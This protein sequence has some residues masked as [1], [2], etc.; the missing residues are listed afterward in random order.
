MISLELHNVLVLVR[1]RGVASF[2]VAVL[3]MHAR[4]F[5]AHGSFTPSENLQPS[6]LDLSPIGGLPT[7]RLL[8]KLQTNRQL[9]LP[10]FCLRFSLARVRVIPT[11]SNLA[12]G[13]ELAL[14]G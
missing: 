7:V 5:L 9:G 1:S 14:R 11:P 2:G 6:I 12:Q 10:R 13:G 4:L 3:H 8:S